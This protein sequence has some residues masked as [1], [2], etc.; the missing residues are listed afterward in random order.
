M[1]F[2]Y[3]PRGTCAQSI[4]FRLENGLVHDIRFSGGCHGNLQGISK[5]AEG[6]E[7]QAVI[8]RLE[9][10][11]CGLKNTSCPVQLAQALRQALE[12][13]ENQK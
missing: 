9:G 7:A 6:M 5:L 1:E 12:A 8:H 2:T 4:R 11:H 10:L 13:A 3:R